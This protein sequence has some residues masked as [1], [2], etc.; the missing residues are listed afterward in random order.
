MGSKSNL[1]ETNFLKLIYQ[2]IAWPNIGNAG[3]LPASTSTGNIFIGL[4]TATPNEDNTGTEANF[5]NYERFAV[6][7]TPASW[8]VGI[9]NRNAICKNGVKILFPVSG[10]NNNVITH[11]GTFTNIIGG[12][13]IHYGALGIPVTTET[14]KA[15]KINISDLILKEK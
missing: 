12:D 5:I 3:G 9:D 15:V 4:F 13:L 7:R 2:N 1:C 11:F 10:G 6:S 14:N 8:I